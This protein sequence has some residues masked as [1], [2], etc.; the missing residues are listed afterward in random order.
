MTSYGLSFSHGLTNLV[1]AAITISFSFA[2][3]TYSYLNT[4]YTSRVSLIRAEK[5]N[6]SKTQITKEQAT[7]VSTY[8]ALF[9]VN[10]L[11]LVS[12]NLLLLGIPTL[13]LVYK[14]SL[15]V[16]LPAL[17]LTYLTQPADKIKIQ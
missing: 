1:G 4:L 17:S 10:T 13:P 12:F 16:S 2:A 8:W 11:F 14:F 6:P 3:L 7:K 15:S 9:F 5:E